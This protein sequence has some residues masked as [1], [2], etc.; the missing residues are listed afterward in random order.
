[1]HVGNK[2]HGL[3]TRKDWAHEW[4]KENVTKPV[5]LAFEWSLF[6][7]TQEYQAGDYNWGMTIFGLKPGTK[8]NLQFS[9]QQYG[10]KY[11]AW[12]NDIECAPDINPQP[13]EV[14]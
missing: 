7:T 1:V 8:F 5:Q 11:Q 3:K 13:G 6:P 14:R 9:W 12:I 2:Q 10:K 4:H